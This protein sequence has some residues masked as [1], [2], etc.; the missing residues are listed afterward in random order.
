MS[1]Y[2]NPVKVVETDNWLLEIKK[3]RMQKLNISSPIIVTSSGN[4]KRLKLENQ[5]DG[6]SI[7]S[8][9]GT[10]PTFDTCENAVGFCKGKNFDGVIA[11][12]GGSV[13]DL[14]KVV[15]AHLCIARSDIYELI[16]YKDKFPQTIASIF[17][18]TT[19]GTASEVTMWGTVWNMGKRNTRSLTRICIQK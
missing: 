1:N 9:V 8:D 4:R 17:L 5:F 2:Y 6:Y 11:L 15:M 3:N 13:M 7:F 19:H 10:N 18:P 12:G 14:A 16:E